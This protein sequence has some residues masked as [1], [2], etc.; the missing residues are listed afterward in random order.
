MKKKKKKNYFQKMSL[1]LQKKI[2]ECLDHYRLLQK[3]P[4]LHVMR[5]K[6]E[7]ENIHINI[8]KTE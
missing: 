7:K 6:E 5:L 8:I 1:F 3:P 4:H 2:N